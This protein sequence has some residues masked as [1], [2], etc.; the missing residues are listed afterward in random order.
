MTPSVFVDMWTDFGAN[1][2]LAS[3]KAAACSL[4]LVMQCC[5]QHQDNLSFIHAC[6][7]LFRTSL[8][9]TSFTRTL[10]VE[11]LF[12]ISSYSFMSTSILSHPGTI[13]KHRPTPASTS[14]VA[15]EHKL[16][17]Q[18]KSLYE[19]GLLKRCSGLP[20]LHPHMSPVGNNGTSPRPHLK[21]RKSCA[22]LRGK[23][24]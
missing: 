3:I 15:V 22:W 7:L 20:N 16:Y 5:S 19:I 8:L 6:Q 4:I 18:M 1:N 17:L 24:N 14:C 2:E 23:P 21:S 12:E 11:A 10:A 9:C 13:T